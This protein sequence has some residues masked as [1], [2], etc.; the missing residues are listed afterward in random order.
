[1]DTG[2]KIVG[3]FHVKLCGSGDIFLL[4]NTFVQSDADSAVR[5]NLHYLLKLMHVFFSFFRTF[6]ASIDWKLGKF[7]TLGAEREDIITFKSKIAFKR[8]RRPNES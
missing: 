2:K 3:R 6:N 5:E 8:N 1:M 4:F 7:F